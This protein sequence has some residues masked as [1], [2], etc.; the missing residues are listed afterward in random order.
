MKARLVFLNKNRKRGRYRSLNYST[1]HTNQNR[2]VIGEDHC[3]VFLRLE[4]VKVESMHIERHL[5]E[6]N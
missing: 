3:F 2:D 5:M 4:V 1:G 6:L